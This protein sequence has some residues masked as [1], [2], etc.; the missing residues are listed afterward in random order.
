MTSVYVAHFLHIRHEIRDKVCPAIQVLGIHT[1]NPFYNEDGSCR[2][3]RPEIELLD[4]G[5]LGEYA[6]TTAK[7]SEDIVE[8]DLGRIRQADGLVAVVKVASIGCSMEIFYCAR[9]LKKPVF[10][11]TTEKYAKHP[12]LVYLAKMS[13]GKVVTSEEALYAS[14]KRWKHAI[15]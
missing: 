15:H 11:L 4:K 9:N 12:W 13:K 7:L 10:I 2:K 5:E 6:I 1:I 3:D 14:L 8:R